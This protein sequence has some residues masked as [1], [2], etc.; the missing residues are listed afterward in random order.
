MDDSWTRGTKW[1]EQNPT[2][3]A[4]INDTIDSFPTMDMK[5]HYFETLTDDEKNGCFPEYYRRWEERDVPPGSFVRPE[6]KTGI[7]IHDHG[8]KH[9]STATV[10]GHGGKGLRYVMFD[11]PFQDYDG[12]YHIFAEVDNHNL[13]IVE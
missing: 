9:C 8:I 11:V 6:H 12:N 2:R 5:R 3:C 7:Y 4:E 13:V 1:H 10:I